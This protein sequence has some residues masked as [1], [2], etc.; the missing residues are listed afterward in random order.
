MISNTKQKT[1]TFKGS[2]GNVHSSV[3]NT[4]QWLCLVNL[5]ARKCSSNFFIYILGF[6][7]VTGYN[8]NR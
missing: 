4:E 7:F 5:V 8:Q 3:F 6:V 2:I 1:F